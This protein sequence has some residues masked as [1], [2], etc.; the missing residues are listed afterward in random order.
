MYCVLQKEKSRKVI[1]KSLRFKLNPMFTPP[2]RK[3]WE[4][5]EIYNNKKKYGENKNAVCW[6]T[7]RRDCSGRRS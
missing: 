2:P 6:C 3:K 4:S 5:S 1:V 7:C